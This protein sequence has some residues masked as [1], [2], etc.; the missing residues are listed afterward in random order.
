M[1]AFLSHSSKDKAFVSS[2]AEQLRPGTYELDS[3]TFDS[4]LL[5]SQAI[6][7]SLERSTMFCLFLSEHSLDSSY[8][9]FE[10]IVGLELLA[11]G[12]IGRF[13]ILC[14]DDQVF[15][16]APDHI[17]YFNIIQRRH[18]PNSAARLIQGLLVS[19]HEL[20]SRLTHPFVGREDDLLELE[21]QITDLRRPSPKSLYISGHFGSGR[22]AVAKKFYS[23]QYPHVGQIMPQVDIDEYSGYSEIYRRVL[24]KI[25][26]NMNA[27]EYSTHIQAFSIASDSEKPRL[28]SQIINSLLG[29][30]EVLIWLN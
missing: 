9:D 18:D 20:C 6:L 16:K 17:K 8:V 15:A 12:N 29:V 30:N 28:I 23:N 3:Q 25:R 26:P 19:S 10:T 4:G 1:R 21:H 27:T 13:L 5:N 24:A 2:V 14:L 11:S 7:S 22:R